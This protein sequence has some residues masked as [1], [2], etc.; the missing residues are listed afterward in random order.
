MADRETER[1]RY[2]KTAAK[3]AKLQALFEAGAPTAD[4]RK[5]SDTWVKR[6]NNNATG[7]HKPGDKQGRDAGV[8]ERKA[9]EGTGVFKRVRHA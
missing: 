1:R 9:P 5:M 7:M 6:Q 3:F 2:K 4:R 8:Q